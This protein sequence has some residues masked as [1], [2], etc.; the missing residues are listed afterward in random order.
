MNIIAEPA[1]TGDRNNIRVQLEK[2]GES[3]AQSWHNAREW[4]AEQREP[5]GETAADETNEDQAEEEP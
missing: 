1:E 5:S 2:I 4:I 3:A